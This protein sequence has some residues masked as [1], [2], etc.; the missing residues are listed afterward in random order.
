MGTPQVS[1]R[2]V[3]A[4]T[5]T[6]D[7][8]SPLG[9]ALSPDNVWGLREQLLA[10]AVDALRLLWWAQTADAEKNRNRPKPIPRPGV[11]KAG[12]TTRGQAMPLEELK[13]QLALPRS[14]IDS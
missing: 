12:R 4:L 9:L 5:V 1:W 10:A 8:Q 13:R 7:P 11:K 14:P 6:C 3:W 2:D